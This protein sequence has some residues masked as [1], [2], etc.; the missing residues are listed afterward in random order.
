MIFVFC[1]I[2]LADVVPARRSPFSPPPMSKLELS[3]Q[4]PLLLDIFEL[5]WG[6]WSN[7]VGCEP[8]MTVSIHTSPVFRESPKPRAT[9]DHETSPRKYSEQA[10]MC[11]G[12]AECGKYSHKLFLNPRSSCD[13]AERRAHAS[14]G[15]GH[16]SGHRA[17]KGWTT[18]QCSA[19]SEQSTN[20]QRGTSEYWI[21]RKLTLEVNG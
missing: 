20:S 4:T 21:V 16:P 9:S 2:L 5:A 7:I 10:S 13:T 14:G 8:F 17:V 6:C 15:L 18:G 1:K 3:K 12:G 19:K 11:A